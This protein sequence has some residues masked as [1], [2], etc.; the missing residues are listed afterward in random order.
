VIRRADIVVIGA[1]PYGLSAAAHLRRAGAECRVFGDP[2][3]FWRTMP[4]GM[5]LRS[6]RSA[7]NIAERAGELS[8]DAFEHATG[9][10]VTTPVPLEQ[11]IAY[12]EWVQRRAVPDVDR[13]TVTR[14]EPAADGFRVTI[15]DGERIAARRVVV[16]CGIAPFAWRP[17]EYDHLPPEVAS[18]TGRHAEPA[19][20]AGRRVA[21][22]GAGQSALEWAAL[23]HA[24]G[25][26]VEVFVRDRRVIWLRHVS[27]YSRLGRLAPIVYAPTDVGPLWYSRLNA[28]PDVFRRLPRRAQ[29]RIAARSI[30]P[31][32]SDWV[33]QGLAEVPVHLR[34]RIASSRLRDGRVELA[35]DDGSRRTVDH[36]LLG[37]GYRVDVA[38]YPMLAPEIVARLRRAG[39][40]PLLGRGLETSVPGLHVLGAPAAWS[41]GPIVRFV[42][43][44]WYSA[45]AL[46]RTVAGRA[47][48]GPA[49]VP[50]STA[51]ALA[52][53][54]RV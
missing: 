49:P 43:G 5:R 4:T 12:G 42:S 50:A 35:L 45:G 11:F 53:P 39:G 52:E 25:A 1:G 27:V 24:A 44:T 2:M 51:P 26:D 31:A 29:T 47:A 48:P 21:V 19:R 3:S 10:S 34:T 38:R 20:F 16:A 41:F 30:R 28:A 17:P 40:Y 22:V 46:T 33:R 18:H 36:L 6:N 13:R 32:C 8:L 37:T 7:T 54:E 9:A 14:V 15:D 23:L